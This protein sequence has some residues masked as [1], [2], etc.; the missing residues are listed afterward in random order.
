M[1]PTNCIMVIQRWV[2]W[3]RNAYQFDAGSMLVSKPKFS[4]LIRWYPPNEGWVKVNIDESFCRDLNFA[5][6]G[7]LIRDENGVWKGGFARRLGSCSVLEAELWRLY[8]G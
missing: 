8:D 1:Q 6:C 5:A 7:G 2:G 3:I 4:G